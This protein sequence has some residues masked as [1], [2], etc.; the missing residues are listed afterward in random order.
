MKIAKCI[1]CGKAFSSNIF[2]S[3][4]EIPKMEIDN[5]DCY[6]IYKRLLAVYGTRYI[7]LL[8]SC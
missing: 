8:T 1:I 4:L 5:D 6:T 7:E 2:V 3:A